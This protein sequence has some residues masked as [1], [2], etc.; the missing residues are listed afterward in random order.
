MQRYREIAMAFSHNGFGY[1]VKELGLYELL[2]LPRRLFLNEQET[3]RKTTGER[4]RFFLEELGP[5]FVKMGQLA[6][7]RSDLIPPDIIQELEK[8]QDH[9]PPFTYDE[10]KMIV[11]EELGEDMDQI[12][13]VF[14]QTP[15]GSASIGQVHYAVLKSGERVAVKVQRPNI[16][17]RIKTDLE[18]LQQLA[19]LAEHRLTWAANYQI[20]AVVDEFSRA[21]LAELD[22]NVEGRNADRIAKQFEDEST[23]YIPKIYWEHTSKKVLTMEYIKG[24]KLN[25]LDAIAEDG[26]DAKVLAERVAH[27]VFQQILVDGFFHAD[28]HPG[29]VTAL[30]KDVVAFIDFG[31]VG[32]L[33]PDMRTHFSTLVIA[34]MRQSTDGV[35]KALTQMGTLPDD[36]HMDRLRLDVDELRDKYYDVP[37]SQV[38]LGEAVNDLFTVANLHRIQI[39]TELTLVAKALLNMEAMVEKL[40]PEISIVKIAEPFG[41]HLLKQR[42]H[43]KK[44]AAD[45]FD[46]WS[47]MEDIVTDLPKQLH[48]LASISKNGKIPIEVNLPKAEWAVRKLDRI[49][50]RISFSIVLLSFSIIMVGLILGSAISGQASLLWSIP[51]IEIG[52]VI[53]ILMFLWLLYSIFRSGRF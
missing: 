6:S 48:K 47:E 23:I 27:S 11:E 20:K 44:I 7:T 52:F 38:S 17:K 39:P 51:A 34:L 16:A 46:Q 37:M 42:Y 41:R 26:N 5:T 24:T 9:V 12:F 36:V 3:H 15:L 14:D 10:V 13:D 4:V 2:S 19:V 45:L 18:I 28:P 29:N 32:R 21:I 53:A 1:I 50:N 31:M 22:Y 43:P 30:P 35:I 49:S 33:T 40:D 8:L 25:N